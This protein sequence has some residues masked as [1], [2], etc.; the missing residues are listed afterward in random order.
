MTFAEAE[1][2][3][4][5]HARYLNGLWAEIHELDAAGVAYLDP[6]R[7]TLAKRAILGS[8]HLLKLYEFLPPW[9]KLGE[10]TTGDPDAA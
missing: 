8:E 1:R 9:Q 2:R 5:R 10:E 3:Y 7:L 6:R 4:F